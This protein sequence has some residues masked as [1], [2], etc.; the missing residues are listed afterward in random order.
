MGNITETMTREP[1]T[2]LVLTVATILALPASRAADVYVVTGQSNG[3]RLSSLAQ[4]TTPIPGGHKIYYYG[5]ECVS[6]PES[7]VF[8][9][10]TGLNPNSMGTELAL[11]LVEQSDDDIILIQY[12]RCGAP[13]TKLGPTSW[14]PGLDPKTSAPYA[15]GL[16]PKFINYIASAKKAAEETLQLTWEMKGLF[17]HQGE[18]DVAEPNATAHKEMLATLFSRFRRDLREDLPIVCGEIRPLND[19]AQ[20]INSGMAELADSDPLTSLA[21]T[22][23]IE[24]PSVPTNPGDVH[25]RLEA[26]Q[27]IGRRFATALGRLN[28]TIPKAQSPQ[29]A[30]Q[31]PN[32]VIIFTDDHA[33]HAI[34][35]YGSKINQTPH[36]D[37]LARDGMRFTQSFVANSICG[38]SRA[39]L[40]TG[41]HSH[42]NGQT[43]NRAIFNDSLPTFSKSLQQAGYDTAVIGKWHLSA[44]PNGFDH[45]AL[46][47]GAFYN[48]QFKTPNG[49]E[50]SHGHATDVITR[51]SIDWIEKRE[52]PSRPFMIWVSHS[53]AHRTW[54][55]P[56]R[57]LTR[58]DDVYIPEPIDLFDNYLGRNSGAKTAQMRISRDLFPA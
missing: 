39:T 45:W 38:P 1:F 27:E 7:S 13:L 50:T 51:R 20:R 4:G 34:S 11:R 48:P 28:G 49:I 29:P 58:Y 10:L 36:I 16:Y 22:S 53:A 42:A 23:D 25:F 54:S 40:L 15:E 14:Y 43:S 52:D 17:W 5:M 41:L 19:G 57:H 35:A 8:Q 6:E 47:Q 46:K 56:T 44:E 26:C 2:F 30:S 18:S 37:R 21:V 12:C 9:V 31:A 32:I 3:Y 55:P 24:S 33:Q